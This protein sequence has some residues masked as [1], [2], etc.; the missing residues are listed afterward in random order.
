MPK[1]RTHFPPKKT[2]KQSEKEEK[3]Q[4]KRRRLPWL[5]YQLLVLGL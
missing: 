1:S 3:Q 4:S 2:K 5:F